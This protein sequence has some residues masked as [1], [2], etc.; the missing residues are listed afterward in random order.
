M[1]GE[2]RERT[3]A[4]EMIGD[5]VQ[6]EMVPFSFPGANRTGEEIRSAALVY[7]ESLQ[8]HILQLLDENNSLVI[9]QTLCTCVYVFRANRVSR[10]TW[11][12]MLPE[13]E[14][15]VKLG[16]DKGGSCMK[17]HAQVCNVPMPNSPRNTSVFTV[18]EAPDTST[19]LHIALTRYKEQVIQLQSLMSRY[20]VHVYTYIYIIY[21]HVYT[22]I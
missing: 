9:V 3:I 1:A 21:M 4:K 12:G 11:H 10:L 7:I 20:K 6:G 5:K 15:W 14:I 8:E 18:F 13:E 17:V 2:G 19:N 22:Y 16:G